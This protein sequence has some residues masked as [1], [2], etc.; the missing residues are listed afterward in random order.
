VNF[1]KRYITPARE[2]IGAEAAEK[3]E[4]E[5]RAMG[6]ERAIAYAFELAAPR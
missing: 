5:G 4:Q 6:W 2:R 1:K 3:A